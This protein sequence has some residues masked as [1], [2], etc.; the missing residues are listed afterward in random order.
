MTGRGELIVEDFLTLVSRGR[1]LHVT[2]AAVL[3]RLS[4]PELAVVPIHDLPPMVVVPVWHT[5]A[6]HP[7][8]ATFLA[9]ARSFSSDNPSLSQ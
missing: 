2:V 1:G 3:D 9:T 8:I 6:E 5:E 7:A 4:R